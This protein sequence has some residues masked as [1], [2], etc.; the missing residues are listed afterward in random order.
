MVS[1]A[2]LHARPQTTDARGIFY[3][4]KGNALKRARSVVGRNK[5]HAAVV[6][7]HG[8]ENILVGTI[9]CSAETI[10]FDLEKGLIKCLSRMGVR[11]TNMSTGGEGSS[12]VPA[13]AKQR[14]R[15]KEINATF[16]ADQRSA[17]RRKEDSLAA[18]FLRSEATKAR[19][20]KM[21][22][23]ERSSVSEKLTDVNRE[24]WKDP[25]I[26]AR[27]IAGM[28]GKKK[29]MT[30]AAIEARRSNAAKRKQSERK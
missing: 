23:E 21:S 13:S 8:A 9:P 26:R 2:Y 22:L 5:Y 17:A 15:M 4:G 24:S 10:A 7:K 1:F 14:Q 19:W 25:E 12:G 3:V 27:R 28:L 11:L 29:T 16:T 30:V 6:S 18:N 20:E